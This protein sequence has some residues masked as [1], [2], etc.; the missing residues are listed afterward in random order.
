V[1]AE[2]LGPELQVELFRRGARAT[3][4][5]RHLGPQLVV[6][7]LCRQY[8][9]NTSGYYVITEQPRKVI[10]LVHTGFVMLGIHTELITGLYQNLALL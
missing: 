5:G 4:A 1:G 6:E 7:A 10:L 2:E 9:I 3:H 8:D